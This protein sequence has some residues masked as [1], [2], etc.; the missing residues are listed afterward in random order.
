MKTTYPRA[1]VWG[2]ALAVSALALTS[3]VATTAVRAAGPEE[4]GASAFAQKCASCHTVGYGRKV[5]PDL[6]GVTQKRDREWLV[7]FIVSPDQ[8]IASGD[9]IAKQLLAEYAIPMPNLGVSPETAREV[10][11]YLDKMSGQASQPTGTGQSTQSS[12]PRSTTTVAVAGSATAGRDLFTGVTPLKN[13]GPACLSCHSVRGLGGAGGGAVAKDLTGAYSVFG[14]QGVT[15]VLKNMPFPVMREIGADKP[16]TDEE[17]A[18]LV[19]FLEEAGKPGEARPAS[20]FSWYLVASAAGWLIIMVLL[21][22]VWRGRL[23]G[24]RRRMVQGGSR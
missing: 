19:A 12:Q 15:S 11:A 13:G 24:V 4:A 16:L 10:L 17:I 14:A 21:G 7:R 20:L 5:G 3:A 18:N 8:V 22:F 1:V 9:P 6:Q 2:I 23:S